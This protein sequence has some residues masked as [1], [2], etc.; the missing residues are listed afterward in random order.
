[1]ARTLN[2]ADI[3]ERIRTNKSDMIAHKRFVLDGL[4]GA[5][6]GG[7][8]HGPSV[9]SNLA[10]FIKAANAVYDDNE[11]LKLIKEDQRNGKE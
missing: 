10:I 4:S 9:R 3:K 7:Q 11:K 5:M 6:K 8:I 1:M 2:K